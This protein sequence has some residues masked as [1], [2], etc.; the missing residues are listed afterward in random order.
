MREK[1]K[2]KKGT[3]W[4]SWSF[5]KKPSQVIYS[6]GPFKPRAAADARSTPLCCSIA[7]RCFPLRFATLYRLTDWLAFFYV[8]KRLCCSRLGKSES[9]HTHMQTCNKPVGKTWFLQNAFSAAP[10]LINDKRAGLPDVSLRRD[11]FL[12][13]EHTHSRFVV[14]PQVAVCVISWFISRRSHFFVFFLNQTK[15]DEKRAARPFINSSRLSAGPFDVSISHHHLPSDPAAF[16]LASAW[17]WWWW[18]RRRRRQRP[19]VVVFCFPSF[20]L[21]VSHKNHQ[22]TRTPIILHTGKTFDSIPPIGTHS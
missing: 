22:P 21:L 10:R 13:F 6:S 17:W 1:I 7:P 3:G 16:R 12:L 19:K 20:F 15:G 9:T 18:W 8:N 5:W 2:I 4:I 14:H 11:P